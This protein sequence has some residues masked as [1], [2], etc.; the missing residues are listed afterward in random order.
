MDCKDLCIIKQIIYRKYSYPQGYPKNAES[1]FHPICFMLC[2]YKACK[3]LKPE[4]IAK[5]ATINIWQ[6]KNKPE[7]RKLFTAFVA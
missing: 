5:N 4:T 6:A 2:K 3:I 7:L 1:F